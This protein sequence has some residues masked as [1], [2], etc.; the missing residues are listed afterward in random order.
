MI[1][2]IFGLLIFFGIILL[3]GIT[4]GAECNTIDN[5][6]YYILCVI[7]I[8]LIIAGYIGVEKIGGFDY[9]RQKSKDR[10]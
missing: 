8:G 2:K 6:T 4:G 7:G 3:I 9:D 5:T 1:K 10:K